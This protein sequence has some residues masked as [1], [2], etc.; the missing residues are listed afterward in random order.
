MSPQ[1]T[2]REKIA[3]LLDAQ[4]PVITRHPS[5]LHA[6]SLGY[7]IIE[8]LFDWE[9]DNSAE[10]C[11]LSWVKEKCQ[12]HKGLYGEIGR[13]VT[14][15]YVSRAERGYIRLEANGR[16]V[17][18]TTLT[19]KIQG[20]KPHKQPSKPYVRKTIFFELGPH[21]YTLDSIH[22]RLLLV[23]F[24]ARNEC[25]NL[26]KPAAHT[27]ASM[28]FADIKEAL[29]GYSTHGIRTALS[30]LSHP[31][32]GGERLVASKEA[33]FWYLTTKGTVAM[34]KA[35]RNYSPNASP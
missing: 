32:N 1:K 4:T 26:H 16:R 35:V 8:A 10:P 19:R 11:P 24:K 14:K 9:K 20:K 15:S 6:G 27:I 21:K 33:G 18:Y 30:A 12:N 17:F 2:K 28:S 22:G 23:L 25:C 31:K 5:H 29:N 13:L 34:R 3:A 7:K